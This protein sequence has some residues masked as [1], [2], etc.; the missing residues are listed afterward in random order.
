MEKN[1]CYWK[2]SVDIIIFN[3][4][5][6]KFIKSIKFFFFAIYCEGDGEEWKDK[7]GSR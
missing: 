4:F 2:M 7:G 1:E 3:F 6:S 5:S